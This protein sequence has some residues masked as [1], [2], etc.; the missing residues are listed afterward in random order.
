M[1]ASGEVV[2]KLPAFVLGGFLVACTP[3]DSDQQEQTRTIPEPKTVLA[4]KSEYPDVDRRTVV[5]PA[6]TFY[7]PVT[8]Y[9][10][11]GYLA[12][13]PKVRWI[14]EMQL[15]T[16]NTN[17]TSPASA[18][19]VAWVNFNEPP[20]P[21]PGWAVIDEETEILLD[22]AGVGRIPTTLAHDD[23]GPDN[24]SEKYWRTYVPGG[25]PLGGFTIVKWSAGE[26][27]IKLECMRSAF[28]PDPAKIRL[29]CNGKSDP[30]EFG[31]LGFSSTEIAE[32]NCREAI[33]RMISVFHHVPAIV[34]SWK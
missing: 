3:I 17:S 26:V 14:V 15:S 24:L 4:W 32:G 1:F 20:I 23:C 16:P 22:V 29:S 13:D 7:V 28:T 8:P 11:I 5:T 9:F 10:R 31:S 21:N 2:A 27:Q 12:V 19:N 30:Q 25:A 34:D 6:G 18:R 33:A